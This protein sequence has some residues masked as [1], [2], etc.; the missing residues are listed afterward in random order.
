MPAESTKLVTN[1]P[2]PLQLITYAGGGAGGPPVA[3]TGATDRP[4]RSPPALEPPEPPEPGCPLLEPDEPGDLTLRPMDPAPGLTVTTGQSGVAELSH[5][6]ADRAN[7]NPWPDAA[8]TV[9]AKRRATFLVCIAASPGLSG[10][11]G[12]PR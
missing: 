4:D 2:C 8:T 5:A 7:R 9:A 1:V 12:S 11:A 3:V 6:V 10:S